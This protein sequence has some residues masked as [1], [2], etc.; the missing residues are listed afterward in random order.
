MQPPLLEQIESSK[1]F[2]YNFSTN[3][4]MSLGTVFVYNKE[5]ILILFQLVPLT[6]EACGKQELRRSVQDFWRRWS[7]DYVSQLH[8]RPKWQTETQLHPIEG[9]LVLVKQENLPPLQWNLGRIVQTFP[10]SDG[11]VR[12][13]LVRTANGL[14]KRAVTEVCILPIDVPQKPGTIEDQVWT[15]PK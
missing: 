8:Q 4:N 13:V 2:A 12:V 15:E 1:N 3:L 10:G 7:R 6:S 11:H 9:V 14:F 5:L